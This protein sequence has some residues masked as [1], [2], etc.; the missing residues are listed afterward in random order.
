MGGDSAWNILTLPQTPE[1][2]HQERQFWPHQNHLLGGQAGAVENYK[3]MKNRDLSK[4]GEAMLPA[5]HRVPEEWDGEVLGEPGPPLWRDG[6][7]GV[8][9]LGF[10]CRGRWVRVP[11]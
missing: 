1:G 3:S 6:S 8:C 11:S 9:I 2:V 5:G 4:W 7:K 10:S